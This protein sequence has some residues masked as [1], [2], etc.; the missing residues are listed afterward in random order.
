MAENKGRIVKRGVINQRYKYTISDDGVVTIM[1]TGVLENGGSLGLK[2]RIDARKP[3]KSPE[4]LCELP[5][6]VYSLPNNK[7]EGYKIRFHK[8]I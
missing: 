6:F 5:L 2:S 8:N 1:G 7:R 3:S 4:S